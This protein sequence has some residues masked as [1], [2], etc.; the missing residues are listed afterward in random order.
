MLLRASVRT[1]GGVLQA[2]CKV[3]AA[4]STRSLEPS[5]STILLIQ[6]YTISAAA[7]RH[8]AVF[9]HDREARFL[10]SQTAWQS[11]SSDEVAF[12]PP[13][14]WCVASHEAKQ[15]SKSRLGFHTTPVV[16]LKRL[17][18]RCCCNVCLSRSYD[19]VVSVPHVTFSSF[20][21]HGREETRYLTRRRRQ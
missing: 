5:E 18:P 16:F 4:K 3:R 11:A 2:C 20:L 21:C 10:M 9:R 1:I 8:D 7:N 12:S 14:V 6:Q 15:D 19:S 13:Q 17:T